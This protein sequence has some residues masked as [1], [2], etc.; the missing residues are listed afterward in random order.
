MS[1][2][3]PNL[4][5]L[6]SKLRRSQPPAPEPSPPGGLRPNLRRLTSRLRR[7]QPPA[8][9]PASSGGVRGWVSANKALAGGAAGLVV[10]A[11]VITAGSVAEARSVEAT[12]VSVLSG[13]TFEVEYDGETRQVRLLNLLGVDELDCLT[14]DARHYLM[15]LLP[16]GTEVQLRHDSERVYD[17]V[18]HAGVFIGE[19]L[20]NAEV[21]AGGFGIAVEEPADRFYDEVLEAQSDASG[22]MVGIY[23]ADYDCSAQAILT[24]YREDTDAV[25]AS[26]LVLDVR[27]PESV[28]AYQALLTTAEERRTAA[29]A[30]L[31]GD[32]EALPL[33]AYNDEFPSY[34][35]L[36]DRYEDGTATLE[37]GMSIAEPAIKAEQER[38]AAEAAAK[39]EAERKTAEEA[40]RRAAEEAERKAA[41][42]ARLAEE[43]R[44]RD[45]EARKATESAPVGGGSSAPAPSVGTDSDYGTCKA[46]NAAGKGPYVAGVDPEYGWYQD[47]DGDGIVCER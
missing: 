43:Q 47:R 7:K 17:G 35:S 39:A 28:K 20:I 22:A 44:Q 33:A 6:V 30:L 24:A 14:Q 1:M 36:V 5:H 25:M 8:P 13:D 18:E 27:D 45:E 12:V 21:A 31:A 46:A 19:R 38:V 41:E 10:C 23:S 15:E 11:G 3:R 42:E 2:L 32:R 34:Q 16:E 29:K 40:A 37:D 4:R 26:A 9:E